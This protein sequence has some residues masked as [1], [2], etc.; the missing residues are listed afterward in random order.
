M[1]ISNGFDDTKISPRLTPG[2]AYPIWK[3]W[4]RFKAANGSI[5]GGEPVDADVDVGLALA[6]KRDVAVKVVTGASALDYDVSFTG[7]VKF[8]D[9]LLSPVS[10][11]EAGTVRCIGLNYKEH[12]AEMKMALPSI[13][14]VFLKA[15]TCIASA[16]E[17]ILLPSTVDYD[18]ADYEVELAIIIG[19]FCKNVSVGDASNY[20]LGYSVANDVTA[21]KHQEKTS[22]WSY[23]KGMDGFCPLGP[24]IVSIKQIPNPSVLQLRT[25]LNGI[26]MQEGSADDMIFSIPEIVSYLSQAC[27]A[28]Q[29]YN[30]SFLTRSGAHAIAW[31][32]YHYWHALWNRGVAK[33]TALLTARGRSANQHKPWAGYSTLP[34]CQRLRR[35]FRT[36]QLEPFR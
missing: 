33:A 29:N 10:Q 24:C 17:P 9:E 23:A 15:S 35:R 8:I 2:L 12:A 16:S 1:G 34:N 11:A 28:K 22:Q 5:Y 20:I 14:T 26:M 19:K 4:V 36:L 25:Y 27:A 32:G 30:T 21:R 6:E 13:P 7:E 3:R 18:E 31:N